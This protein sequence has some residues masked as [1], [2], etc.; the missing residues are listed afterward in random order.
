[1]QQGKGGTLPEGAV[2]LPS[3]SRLA[4]ALVCFVLLVDSR[5]HVTSLKTRAFTSA[6]APMGTWRVHEPC[7]C[8]AAAEEALEGS[9]EG[10]RQWLSLGRFTCQLAAAGGR[11]KVLQWARVNGRTRSRCRCWPLGGAAEGAR[12]LLFWSAWTHREALAE[13]QMVIVRWA[14]ESSCPKNHEWEPTKSLKHATRTAVLCHLPKRPLLFFATG[15]T[16]NRLAVQE[17]TRRQRS[18]HATLS[19]CSRSQAC[20]LPPW[21]PAS[22]RSRTKRSGGVEGLRYRSLSKAASE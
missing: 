22:D 3:E 12:E 17:A 1:V 5:P 14:R 18:A 13:E 21:W 8:H 9:A 7:T 4:S 6:A 16:R 2:P 10:P 20:P 19:A 15:G 11:P